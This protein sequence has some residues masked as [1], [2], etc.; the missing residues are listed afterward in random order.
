VVTRRT[1]FSD[2]N[3]AGAEIIPLHRAVEHAT[4]MNAACRVYLDEARNT[5]VVAITGEIDLVSI[6]SLEAAIDQARAAEPDRVLIDATSAEFIS[7][8]GYCMIGELTESV[9]RVTLCSRSD[10]A[11][12]VMTILGFPDVVCA[13]RRPSDA[14]P[15]VTTDALR[16]LSGLVFSSC[17]GRVDPAQA[18]TR[19]AGEPKGAI[20]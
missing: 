13:V 19:R 1:R 14:A 9:D 5:A 16:S 6:P 3:K 18:L 2:N 4:I 15:P 8:G 17:F 10:L 20:T 12:R 11:A 7:V